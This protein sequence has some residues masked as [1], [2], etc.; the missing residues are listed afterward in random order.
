MYLQA[1]DAPHPHIADGRSLK[2][3]PC[4]QAVKLEP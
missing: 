4:R 1:L 2:I 3:V